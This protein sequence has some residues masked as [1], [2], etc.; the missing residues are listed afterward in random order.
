MWHNPAGGFG[1]GTEPISTELLGASQWDM[2]M[3]LEAQGLTLEQWMQ[4]SGTDQETFV[5]D[6]RETATTAAKVELDTV[7]LLAT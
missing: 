4:L 7:R 3:R 6:L 1:F 2:A 5:A